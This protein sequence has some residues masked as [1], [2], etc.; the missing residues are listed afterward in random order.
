[1][2]DCNEGDASTGERGT[3]SEESGGSSF[4]GTVGGLSEQAEDRIVSKLLARL[5]SR[6]KGASSSF[7][8]GK[9]CY[10]R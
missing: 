6:E 10:L 1:M 2:A 8:G 5:S 7:G 3:S 4:G 9:S